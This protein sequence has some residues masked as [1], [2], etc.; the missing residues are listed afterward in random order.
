MA[1]AG[2]ALSPTPFRRPPTFALGVA[3]W[4][5]T[6]GDIARASE[7]WLKNCESARMSDAAATRRRGIPP[8]VGGIE[9]TIRRAFTPAPPGVTRQQIEARPG[10]FPNCAEANPRVAEILRELPSL[11]SG[12]ILD[13]EGARRF[14][15]IRIR[16]MLSAAKAARVGPHRSG[17][18]GRVAA[19]LEALQRGDLDAAAK[20]VR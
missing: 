16:R 9:R 12:L 13:T 19:S 2:S 10:D 4:R 7:S 14:S 11:R 8:I 3:P 18:L 6:S 15:R 5:I 1:A 17:A 20:A